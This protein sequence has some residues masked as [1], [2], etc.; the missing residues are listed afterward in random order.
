MNLFI[1]VHQ[2]I[3]K[4]LLDARVDFIV[5]GGYSV[6]F[7]GY[8]RTTG[9]V[10]IW[11]RPS[12]ENKQKLLSALR[13]LG[14]HDNEI[15]QVAEINFTE[16]AIFSMGETPEKIDFLTRINQVEYDNADK[17]KIIAMADGLPIPFLHLDDLVLS[18]INTGRSQDKADIDMLQ[19]IRNAKK[20]GS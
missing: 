17:R 6:I 12:N 19:K 11:L 10:D 5:I 3:I 7:H 18:K 14:F 2:E 13:Q 1:E 8:Q 15:E 9:D 16:H 4:K 20:G